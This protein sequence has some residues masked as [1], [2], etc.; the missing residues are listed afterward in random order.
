MYNLKCTHRHAHAQWNNVSK[1]GGDKQE[2]KNK[3][4][5][6]GQL[7]DHRKTASDLEVQL[8]KNQRK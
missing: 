4:R 6:E 3:S 7:D 1:K 5:K 2:G 8:K